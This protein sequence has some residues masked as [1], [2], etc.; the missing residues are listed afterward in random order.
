MLKEVGIAVREQLPEGAYL[1]LFVKVDKDWQRTARGPR[2]PRLLSSPG[3]CNRSAVGVSS[4]RKAST[5]ARSRVRRIGG[6]ALTIGPSG[7]VAVARRGSSTATTP[8]SV[9]VR[10]RRPAPWAS[11]VAARGRSMVRK[12]LGPGPLPAGLEQRLVG[13]GERQPVDGDQRQRAAGHVD[14]LPEAHGGEQAG[15]L[16][17]GE[18]GDQRRLGQ[19]VLGQ[20]G[21]GERGRS[22]STAACIAR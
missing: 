5:S 4:R 20:H 16:V 6:R 13:A 10:M 17:G 11:S 21:H 18:A 12:A 14:A 7:S 8:R 15:G 3:D 19:V 22:A 2:A 9:A 1:E